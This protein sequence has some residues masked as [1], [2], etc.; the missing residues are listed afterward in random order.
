MPKTPPAPRAPR[1]ARAARAA[2][3]GVAALGIA[4][5]L[6]AP[7]GAVTPETLF[8]TQGNAG[9]DVRHYDVH[10][11]Y[12]PATN[13]LAA[14][15]TLR[16]TAPDRLSAF[17][18]DLSGLKVSAVDV[19][20]RA[21]TWARTGHELVVTPRRAVSGDFTT[22]VRYGGVPREHTDSDGSTEGWVRTG[23]GA[24]ALGEPVGTMT[25]LPADNTPADKATY[26]FHVRVPRGFQAAANGDL[27]RRTSHAG[28][29]TWDWRETDPMSTYLATVSIGHFDV[30]HSATTSVSGRTIPI[31]SFVDPTSTSTA[32]A[33]ALLP[34]VIA[35]EE[36]R[37]GAYPYTSAGMIVDDADVGYALETQTRP[38]YPGSVHTATLVHEMAHQW[39]G[40]SV[41]LTDWHDI[42]LAEG[43]A[44]YAEWL[45]DGAHGGRTPAQHFDA[46]YARPAG[47]GLWHPAPTGFTD[48]SDLFGSPGYNRGAMTLQVLRERVG[49]ADFGRILKAWAAEHRHGNA[50]TADFV[51]LAER[52]S[53]RDLGALFHDWLQQA[54]RPAGY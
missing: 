15:T 25:W 33:R 9:Y 42:W 14:V 32:S 10:L 31:W 37:F 24:T 21:A 23:D 27:A 49:A 20:G 13:H 16:A 40:D 38:F 41:T 47:N 34:K 48:S 8:P 2:V 26:A 50:R 36:K 35:F 51:A 19:D 29:T 28:H 43:F 11:D 45:W 44:T 3:A 4:V 6:A 46:L 39:Y 7:A 5:G 17:H 54:G 22:T 53:G 1:A 52:V 12:A 30:H 18:L